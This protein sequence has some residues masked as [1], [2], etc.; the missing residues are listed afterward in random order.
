MEYIAFL[1]K[2]KHTKDQTKPFSI[3]SQINIC[4]LWKVAFPPKCVAVRWPPT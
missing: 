3:K 2:T 1:S 4:K